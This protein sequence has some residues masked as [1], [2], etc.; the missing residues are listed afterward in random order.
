MPS[1]AASHTTT[2][3][4]TCPVPTTAR[5]NRPEHQSAQ[6][7]CALSVGQHTND[8]AC[9]ALR[10]T[11]TYC[12][13]ADWTEHQPRL[14]C[15]LHL[16]CLL[17]RHT[18]SMPRSGNTEQQQPASAPLPSVLT[19]PSYCASLHYRRPKA[20]SLV[21]D[22]QT[23]AGR[24]FLLPQDN[25]TWLSVCAS[26]GT[27]WPMPNK[28]IPQHE[29]INTDP[30]AQVQLPAPLLRKPVRHHAQGAD[31]PRTTAT[32]HSLWNTCLKPNGQTNPDSNGCSNPALS[33]SIHF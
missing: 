27:T 18:A 30:T 1:P 8:A 14:R 26:N 12:A 10:V 16:C 24:A 19:R 6:G 28:P 4:N 22:Q 31:S 29:D 33:P 3:S 11:P 20:L 25:W 2:G 15:N 9:H 23:R 21:R 5:E 13:L 17:D 7:V 32:G